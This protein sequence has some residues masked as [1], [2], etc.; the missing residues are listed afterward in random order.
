M[1][2]QIPEKKPQSTFRQ[3][4]PGIVISLLMLFL[5]FRFFDWEDVAVALRL[6]EWI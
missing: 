6:A 4:V 1:S 5:L 2:E 3:M